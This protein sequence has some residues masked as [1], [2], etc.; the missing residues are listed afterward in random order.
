M[1][2]FMV[3]HK[4]LEAGNNSFEVAD[5]TPLNV[6][7]LVV[8]KGAKT[9]EWGRFI[10]LAT[11]SLMIY[12]VFKFLLDFH[13]SR[14]E[15][16]KITYP[17]ITLIFCLAWWV[18]AFLP[19]QS[20]LRPGS[21][22]KEGI[23]F[24]NLW[25]PVLLHG[26]MVAVILTALSLPIRYYPFL[27]ESY[28]GIIV[29]LMVTRGMYQVCYRKGL[30]L[31]RGKF[32]VAGASPQGQQLAATLVEKWGRGTFA[33]AFEHLAQHNRN[34]S[35]D[36]IAFKKYCV[37]EEVDHIF[38]AFPALE[39]GQIEAISEFASRN[40][41]RCSV[42]PI[43]EPALLEKKNTYLIGDIH[44][45]DQWAHPLQNALNRSLKRVF[46][47]VF[48]L[49]VILFIF[50]W[51]IPVIG[52]AIKMSSPGPIFF[53]QSRPGKRNKT[54]KCF[55]FR[56]MRINKQTELQATLKDPR[57]TAVGQF[58][59]KTSLDE[60]PQFFNVFFGDMS[61]VGPRPNMISQ[62]EYYSQ[63]IPEYPMRHAVAPGI[64]GYAQVKGFRGETKQLNLMQKRIDYDL[65]YIHK[66]SFWFDVKIIFLT[67][68][69]MLVGEEN[70]Y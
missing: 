52:L 32:V 12:G 24:P 20:Y 28:L 64:T 14:T 44:I 36:L 25:G 9:N 66:W 45:Y 57:V 26:G 40:F 58:L 33:G 34:F 51:M 19:S 49:L 17:L 3:I 29:L 65:A 43:T 47:V 53:V 8:N 59:R 23:S 63:L 7:H 48:S 2:N 60:L 16:L 54:F 35:E 31:S 68:K 22:L 1:E 50:P 42:L 6:N 11:E 21:S 5:S 67:V 13:L 70:A 69:N 30:Q 62:L 18:F 39:H 61:V 37:E 56:T 41:I 4:D 38:I 46:D 27:I 10:L 55:K 15:L